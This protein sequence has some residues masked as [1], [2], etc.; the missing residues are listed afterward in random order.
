M[1][2]SGTCGA[3]M[4][5]R[6]EDH[7]AGVPSFT[8]KEPLGVVQSGVDIVRKVVREDCCYG[9]DGM[10]GE[11]ETSLRR[12]GNW[13]IGKRLSCTQDRDVSRSGGVSRHWGSEVFSLRGSDVDVVRV[14]G[15]IVVEWGE[16]EGVEE[17]LSHTR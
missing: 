8:N 13:G 9:S 11:R 15:D 16:E 12:G 10:V 2:F 3:V 4:H 5:R 7:S 6:D 1:R 14:Y 17:F